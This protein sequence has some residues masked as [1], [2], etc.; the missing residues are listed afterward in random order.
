MQCTPVG[1]AAAIF[2]RGNAP[3]D[4][5]GNVSGMRIWAA[6]VGIVVSLAAT[7][8]HAEERVVTSGDELPNVIDA[9]QPG[10]V[11]VLRDGQ[12]NDVFIH[13]TAGGAKD[14]PLTIRAQTPGKVVLGGSSK[15]KL[16]APHVVVDGLLFQG[17]ALDD[18]Q[19]IHFN[20]DHGRVTNCAVIDYNPREVAT[21]YYWVFFEGHYNRLDHCL[22]KNKNHQEPVIGNAGGGSKPSDSKTPSR[23]NTVDH[24]YFL[25]IPHVRGRNGR[26]IFRIWGYGGNEELGDDGSFFTIER[27]LFE[28][29]HGEGNEIISLKSNRN[30]VRGNTIR[31]T[32]GEITNRSGNFNRIEDNIILADGQ[33]GAGGI[34][35]C[36]QKHVVRGNYIEGAGAGINVYAGEHFE[37]DLTG[38]FEPVVRERAPLKRVP[39]Y[40]QVREATI[41]NNTLADIAGHD[42]YI[43][44]GYKFGWPKAQR[45]LAP[46]ACR[47]AGNVIIKRTGGVAVAGATQD[48]EP[49]LERFEF[50]PNVFEANVIVGEKA[51][52][53]FESARGGFKNVQ[54]REKP[55]IKPLTSKDVGPS[56]RN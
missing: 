20:S 38:K 26:E 32:R 19:V 2:G 54:A 42:L 13:V 6:V 50:K 49:P 39:R 17:G 1:R 56:W 25:D 30:V 7:T 8:A 31:A 37:S 3:V 47:I 41:E 35:I 5:R 40:G 29:A 53:D 52:V 23:H 12:W 34:R 18:G 33:D 4:R 9:S 24:C 48:R 11:I 21:G 36:G 15:L 45:V 27:N 46:E 44:G 10:D 51:T 22:L 16:A 43:G 28:R 14:K 55:A